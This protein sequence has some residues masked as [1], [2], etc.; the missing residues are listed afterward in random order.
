MEAEKNKI[1]SASEALQA[2]IS[3]KNESKMSKR[4]I[5][6]EI[7]KD[8]IAARAAGKTWAEIVETLKAVGINVS[9]QHIKACI[10]KGQKKSM[11]KI[12]KQKS[13][14]AEQSLEPQRASNSTPSKITGLEKIR[15]DNPNL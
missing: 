6:L 2:L 9:G 7:K 5:I 15:P 12:P 1:N 3:N 4:E 13:H 10:Q 11:D 14:R 8:I